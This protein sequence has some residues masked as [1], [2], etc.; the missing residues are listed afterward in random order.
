MD[1]QLKS[2]EQCSRC[3]KCHSFCPIYRAIL[4][5]RLSPRGKLYI[6]SNEKATNMAHD[7]VDVCLQCGRCRRLCPSGVDAGA[8]IHKVRIKKRDFHWSDR[9]LSLAHKR[10]FIINLLKIFPNDLLPIG[11]LPRFLSI[12][13]QQ[14]QE[15]DIRFSRLA[16]H[17]MAQKMPQRKRPFSKATD[18]FLFTGC[19]QKYIFTDIPLNAL[20]L[21]DE[22]AIFISEDETCCGLFAWTAGDVVTARRLSE[23]NLS[24][25]QKSGSNSIM[26]FCSSCAFT[27]RHVWPVLFKN[28]SF[29]QLTKKLSQNLIDIWDIIKGYKLELKAMIDTK[30]IIYHIPCHE[31]REALRPLALKNVLDMCCGQG[32]SFGVK[33]KDIGRQVF[34]MA[35]EEFIKSDSHMLV[36]TCSGCYLRWKASIAPYPV[37]EAKEIRHLAEFIIK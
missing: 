2:D 20:K 28:T 18:V 10:P 8:L 5:E 27:I 9:L 36:T 30:K 12:D 31:D 33:Y 13:H 3:G 4:D 16:F 23:K 14:A 25:I 7:I 19:I 26:T 17:R 32:G 15:T 22:N 1:Y 21:F 29:E 34:K 6:L 35:K 24:V 37:H 11:L